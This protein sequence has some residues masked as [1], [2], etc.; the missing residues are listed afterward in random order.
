MFL[1]PLLDP[2]AT[3]CCKYLHARSQSDRKQHKQTGLLQQVEENQQGAETTPQHCK[4]K[5]TTAAELR[6]LNNSPTHLNACKFR[7]SHTRLPGHSDHALL[8]PP[9]ADVI[10]KSQD[11]TDEL[12]KEEK[13]TDSQ[14]E[15]FPGATS[16]TQSYFCP[17][18]KL[19][20]GPALPLTQQAGRQA[21]YCSRS[22]GGK[23]VYFVALHN[24]T[25]RA[26]MSAVNTSR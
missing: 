17:G 24:L 26:V 2:Q 14:M 23:I 11:F 6:Q 4:Q 22:W 18:A 16:A 20:L 5:G 7:V 21:V 3:G 1:L 9:K 19:N 12:Q 8:L 13:F 10:F 15:C 25:C